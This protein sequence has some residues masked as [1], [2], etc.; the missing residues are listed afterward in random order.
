MMQVNL[1]YHHKASLTFIF[2]SLIYLR[3]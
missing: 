2:V 1:H 3:P